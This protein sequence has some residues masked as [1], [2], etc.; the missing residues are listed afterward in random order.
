MR[1]YS[2]LL[3]E[4]LHRKLRVAAAQ[5][6]KTMRDIVLSLLEAHFNKDYK[7]PTPTNPS[8]S[9]PEPLPD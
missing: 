6:D 2:L 9:S 4:D 5:E 8:Q 1:P 3:P 7:T